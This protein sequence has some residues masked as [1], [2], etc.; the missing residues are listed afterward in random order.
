MRYYTSR[1]RARL[2][3]RVCLLLSLLLSALLLSCAEPVPTPVPVTIRFAHHDYEKEYYESLLEAFHEEYPHITV[4]LLPKRWGQLS[5]LRP[6][7]ADVFLSHSGLARVTQAQGDVL[8]L[9][10]WIGGET[11]FDLDDFYPGMVALY[12]RDDKV[13][14]VPSGTN[15]L[16]IFFNKDLFDQRGVPYPEIGWTWDDFLQ[17][18]AA[19]RDRENGVFGYASYNPILDALAFIHQHGGQIYDEPPNTARMHFDDPLT[20]EALEWWSGL[21]HEY[22]VAPTPVQARSAFEHWRGVGDVYQGIGK[23]QV[24]MWSGHFLEAGGRRY[25]WEGRL[26]W[27]FR[28]GMAPMPVDARSATFL[29]HQALLVFSQT[30]VPDACWRWVAFVSERM[31]HVMAPSRKSLI[32]S[33]AYEERVGAE[34]A[35]VVRASMEGLLFFS[36]Y[37]SEPEREIIGRFQYALNQIMD[38]QSQ[39]REAMEWLQQKI[40]Q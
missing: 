25:T 12:T 17:T 38:G 14:A 35:A 39:P 7:E 19:I 9:D 8:S 21:I 11:S 30:E 34:A 15:P 29:D 28:W 3:G 18:A 36:P 20:L 40:T 33:E 13:F 22:N 4:E 24:G 23:E 16:V 6:D 31:P 5:D 26:D 32:A 2:S 37:P 1:P 10:P 27:S